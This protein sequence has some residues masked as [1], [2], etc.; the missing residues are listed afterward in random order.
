MNEKLTDK[1]IRALQPPSKGNKITYCGELK[2][3]GCR[4]TANG[5]KAFILNYRAGKR[6]RRLTIGSY[7][8]WS[9][10]RA[11]EQAAVFKR[12]ID[13][14]KDPLSEKQ[15]ER[16]APTVRDLFEQYKELRIAKK[17][18]RA[19]ADEMSMWEQRILPVF[20]K[21]KLTDLTLADLERLHR[22]ITRDF[23]I[24][25][26]RVHEVFRAALNYAKDQGWITR[27]PADGVKKNREQPRHRYLSNEELVALANAMENHPETYSVDAIRLILLTGARKSEALQA[28]WPKIDLTKGVWNKPSHHTKQRRMHE[29]PLSQA[30]LEL[31]RKLRQRSNNPLFV[32][33]SPTS[34]GPLQDVRKTWCA[35]REEATI[36]I[37]QRLDTG[38]E[39][40]LALQTSLGR[41]PKVEEVQALAMTM[42]KTLPTGL[43]DVRVH[44][45]RHTYASV[46]VGSGASLPIIG[47]LLGHTQAQSTMR[48]SHLA[49]DPLRAAT[50]IVGQELSSQK[51]DP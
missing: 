26:N 44:D 10:A 47:A 11:R 23:P 48:Y 21:T 37:W 40:L 14:G 19:A 39:L 33:P 46:L 43:L 42:G 13:L 12:H 25:A 45:L 49:S 24:R 5:S 41:K 3:F 30:A 4:V 9:V 15:A 7:P 36:A 29:V 6:E 38:S 22:D 8:E 34:G 1:T 16:D 2:G 20:G 50:N 35:L 27:N 18:T 28:E 51:R 31:L 32:F 17:S